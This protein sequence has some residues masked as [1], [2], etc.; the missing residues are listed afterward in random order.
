MSNV[1]RLT[2]GTRIQVRTG[3]LAGV[4]PEG[5][6]GPV[7]PAGPDGPA[8]PPGPPGPIGQIL[9][10][11]SQARVSGPTAASSGGDTNI[12]FASVTHDDPG[13]ATS[14]TVFTAQASGDY[15]FTAWVG[16][17]TTASF[18][19]YIQS[20][21]DNTIVVRSSFTGLYGAL[22]Y[23]YRALSGE[24]FRVYIN[25]NAN[26]SVSSGAFSMTRVGSGPVGPQGPAGPTGPQGPAG[27]QGPQGPQGS[28]SGGFATYEDLLPG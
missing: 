17:N 9:Q 23:A 4:G 5:P 6:L 19:L 3:V 27:P 24:Q 26:V 20:S 13:N 14:S 16:L 11:Q 15:L 8:G 10:V 21:D 12:A 22:S 2:N 1:V 28:A 25:P 18:D 7:G